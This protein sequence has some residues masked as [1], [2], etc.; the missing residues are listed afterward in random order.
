MIECDHWRACGVPHGGCCGINRFGGRPS[1]GTCRKCLQQSPQTVEARGI[2]AQAVS[3]VKAEAS[4]LI[5][6][7]PLEIVEQRIAECRGCQYLIAG[8]PVG[9]CKRCGCGNRDSAELSRKARL[10][11]ATCPIGRWK[12][13]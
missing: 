9:H 6:E 2:L 7:C 10:P 5:A 8:N 1:L 13:V 11:A 12:A 4:G 3:W